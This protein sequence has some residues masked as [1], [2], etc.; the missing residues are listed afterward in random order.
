MCPFVIDEK[1]N[2]SPSLFHV[3]VD[4]DETASRV[5]DV[6]LKE[7]TGRVTFMPLNRLNPRNPPPPNEDDAEP[8]IE[9]LRYDPRFEKA[10]QQVFGK[11]CVCKDLTIAASYVRSHGINTITL[12]GDKV[13]RK[14]ALTGG[15]HDVR[16]SRIEGIKNVTSWRAK[17]DA[18][19][20]RSDEV[21]QSISRLE[22]EITTLAG[23]V[24]VLNGQQGHIREER[25]RSGEQGAVLTRE[26]E[27]VKARIV[28][29]EMDIDELEMEQHSLQTRIAGYN[30]ELTTPLS[31]GLTSQEEQLIVAL[32]KE[33]ERR[34]KQML[35]M[36]KRK[37]QVCFRLFFFS[38]RLRRLIFLVFFSLKVRRTRLRSS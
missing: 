9:K 15:Y 26:K 35:E 13:D 32:G 10:F 1:F 11:T 12:D 27:R 19:R 16:R 31:N 20:K 33:V 23:K 2:V 17:Y 4:T 7:K 24:T 29:V 36:S 8:L 21:K 34:K 6:M 37:N 30:Q 28:K 3:V 38:P 22:Q 14:G 25:D 18:D 5:L